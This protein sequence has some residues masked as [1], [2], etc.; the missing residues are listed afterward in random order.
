MPGPHLFVDR[1]DGSTVELSDA[2]SRHLLRSLRVRRGEEVTLADG[3]GAWARGFV[4]ADVTGRAII[5]VAEIA[6]VPRPEPMVTVALAPPTGERL[7]WAV[8]KLAEL[9]VDRIVLME[10][11]RSVR[12]WADDRAGRAVSRMRAVAREAAMQSRQAYL[13]EVSSGLTL[14]AVLGRAPQAL[15][16][17]EGA[18]VP[19]KRVLPDDPA[20]LLLVVGPE[21]GFSDAEVQAAREAGALTASLGPTILRSETAA[22]VSAALALDR[23]GRLG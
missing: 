7:A 1:L 19:L 12:R 23:Y 13:M 22:M 10:S 3:R 18:S 14:G 11:E 21:G 5:E 8:Q 20:D 9:G 15:L 6:R 2:D 4:A 17:W 16:L